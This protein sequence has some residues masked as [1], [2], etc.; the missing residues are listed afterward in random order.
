MDLSVKLWACL[1]G[2]AVL[3]IAAAPAQAAGSAP[4]VGSCPTVFIYLAAGPVTATFSYNV[5]NVGGQT[6]PGLAASPVPAGGGWTAFSLAPL[7]MV[8]GGQYTVSGALELADAAGATSSLTVNPL[9][10]DC[11]SFS[12]S[13]PPSEEAQDGGMYPPYASP[14][15]SGYPGYPPGYFPGL[16]PTT[17]MPTPVLRNGYCSPE[18]RFYNLLVGQDQSSSIDPISGKP[19]NQLHLVPAYQDPATGAISCDFPLGTTAAPGGT[20]PGGV[21]SV[22]GAAGMSVVVVVLPCPGGGWQVQVGDKTYSTCAGKPPKVPLRPKAKP[23]P[24]KPVS[25]K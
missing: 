17:P 3:A 6:S 8:G 4:A 15:F 19:Y 25:K 5:A 11:G 22:P 13:P 1:A 10:V 9:S 21:T 23:R 16:T 18:G 14:T 2:V 20:V 7:L 12:G 24:K